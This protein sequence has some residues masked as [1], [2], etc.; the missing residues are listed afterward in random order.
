MALDCWLGR[1]LDMFENLALMLVVPGSILLVSLAIAIPREGLQGGLTCWVI[2]CNLD[3]PALTGS[4]VKLFP[5]TVTTEG[6]TR[7]KIFS[8]HT[9]AKCISTLRFGMLQDDEF[10]LP[11]M[12]MLSV[13]FILGP[14]LWTYLVQHARGLKIGD[15]TIIN[16]LVTGYREDVQWWEALVLLRKMAIFAVAV[17]W[18]LSSDS[19]GNN[20]N[21]SLVMIAAL[22]MNIKMK[23]Y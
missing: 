13:V 18:P 8:M 9:E 7:L 20:A 3:M 1:P 21:L 10:L 6:G 15:S 2:W 16:F 12:S 17:Y 11:G 22:L 5:C 23:P 14:L 4:V 19:H